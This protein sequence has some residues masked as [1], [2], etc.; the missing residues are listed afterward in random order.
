[1]KYFSSVVNKYL[2]K[3]DERITNFRKFKAMTA[4]SIK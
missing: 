1:M 4:P 2:R 3:N